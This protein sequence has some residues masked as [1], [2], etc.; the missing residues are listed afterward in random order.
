MDYSK[1]VGW[2][3]FTVGFLII[4]WTLLNSYSIFTLQADVPEFFS[5]KE[6]TSQQSSGGGIEEQLQNIIG[7]QLKGMIPMDTFPIVLNLA[8]WSILAFILIFGGSQIASLG[9]KL[10]K[11]A[12]TS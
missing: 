2:L 1:I 12:K 9:I 6:Q 3:V 11:N 4:A 10:I 5:V 7:D 8:I